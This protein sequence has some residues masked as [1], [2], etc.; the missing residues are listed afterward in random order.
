M[1]FRTLLGGLAVALALPFGAA[2]GPITNGG[3]ETGDFTGFDTIGDT[4]IVDDTFGAEI[5]G[6]DFAALAS[7]LNDETGDAEADAVATFLGLDVAAFGNQATEGSAI[8][9]QITGAAGEA[10]FFSFNFLTDEQTPSE[11]N[12][13]GF[14]SLV[15]EGLAG[16]GLLAETFSAFGDSL[17]DFDDETG[18]IT[19][20]VTLPVAG[21]FTLGFGAFH[22]ID[23]LAPSSLLIDDIFIDVVGAGGPGATEIALADVIPVTVV[24]VPAP[25][26]L[27]GLGLAGLIVARRRR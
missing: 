14:V 8:S 17:S 2:A 5:P 26:A 20:F 22:V 13:F 6:G 3:F 10:V 4:L 25:L 9:A 7:A 19:G 11:F 23:T 24:P 21:S 15:G 12:D 18:T 16:I 1:T 27:M